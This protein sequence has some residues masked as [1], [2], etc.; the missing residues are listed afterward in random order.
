MSRGGKHVAHG[1]SATKPRGAWRRARGRLAHALEH[2]RVRHQVHTLAGT[3]GVCRWV[4]N[5]WS[6]FFVIGRQRVFK[7]AF[8]DACHERRRHN[9]RGGGFYRRRPDERHRDHGVVRI[10]GVAKVRPLTNTE[11]SCPRGRRVLVGHVTRDCLGQTSVPCTEL[12]SRM[13][14]KSCILRPCVCVQMSTAQRAW[15]A[16]S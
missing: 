4:R 6:M 8:T 3:R 10:E 1:G 2:V 13:S 15:R 11:P 7:G 9:E 5:G 12:Y 14:L 16:L